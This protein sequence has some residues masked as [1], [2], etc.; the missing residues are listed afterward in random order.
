MNAVP[1]LPLR[2]R[3]STEVEPARRPA[4][5]EQRGLAATTA[6]V[7]V[8]HRQNTPMDELLRALRTA[9]SAVIVVDNREPGDHALADQCRAA[10]A[11]CL[12][13]G[14][15][16]ALAGAYNLA[17]SHLRG[18][19]PQVRQVLFLDE[20]SDPSRL[21][22]FLDD[23]RTA[24][25]ARSPATAAVTA[26]YRER[27]TGLRARYLELDRWRLRYLPREFAGIARVAFVI[28]SMSLWSVAA[29]ERIGPFDE[30]LALDH[31]DTDACL[32]ARHAGL[33]LYVHGDH[34]FLH[35]IGQRRRYR[36][37]GR[38]LQAGGHP[39]GRRWLIARNTVWLAKRELVRE[40][41]F[42]GLCA[43]RLAYEAVGIVV[44]EDDKLGKLWALVTGAVR[45]LFTRWRA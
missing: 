12:R 22:A 18:H 45:G 9:L 41:A 1:D 44:A 3:P 23:P 14:N 24:E 19:R 25:L 28:N 2:V 43:S 42:A 35:T 7:L 17:L 5:D 6:A 16:G 38:E 36:L 30:R 11:V 20:D 27:A 10:A 8:V 15:R 29:L 39:S 26:A 32:R 31:I 34:E 21:A 37:F 13:N 4:D 40:P 33:A